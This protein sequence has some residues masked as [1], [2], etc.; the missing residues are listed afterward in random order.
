MGCPCRHLLIRSAESIKI[1]ESIVTALNIVSVIIFFSAMFVLRKD[2]TNPVPL[3][4]CDR[5]CFYADVA[6][7]RE[8]RNAGIRK[9]DTRK[10]SINS[11]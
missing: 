4:I 8:V 5:Y 11:L 6:L 10:Q 3:A 2:R 1:G 7:H 9:K